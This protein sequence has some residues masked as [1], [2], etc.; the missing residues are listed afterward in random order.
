[1]QTFDYPADMSSSMLIIDH[2]VHSVCETPDGNLFIKLQAD[3]MLL[4]VKNWQVIN[5]IQVKQNFSLEKN[6][7]L[8]SFDIESFPFVLSYGRDS[9]DLVNLKTGRVET[10]IKGSAGNIQG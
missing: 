7:V 10:L 6:L 9:Y 3:E 1:M 2:K 8:P 5:K 4:F